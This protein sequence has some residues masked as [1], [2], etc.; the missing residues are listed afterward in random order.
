M[1]P[2][3][4]SLESFDSQR[5]DDSAPTASY[6]DGYDE[7]YAAGLQAANAQAAALSEDCLHALN[8]ID[9]T[10]AEARRQTLDALTPFLHALAHKVLPHCVENGFADQ[11]AQIL[12]D[13]AEQQASEAVTLHVHPS[14]NAAIA[15]VAEKT[16]ANVII[17][18]DPDLGQHSAWIKHAGT[19][20]HL[21]MD[22]LLAAIA[23]TLRAINYL[24]KREDA[25]G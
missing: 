21:D 23:E 1:M 7:G 4:L 16:A 19:E 20:A 24:E 8:T 17:H 12:V 2:Q 18:A 11:I 14:Q 6:Q 25:H 10:Y 15:Q 3:L 9:F 22:A 13:A 5:V